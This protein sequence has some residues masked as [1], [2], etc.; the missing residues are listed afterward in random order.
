MGRG[1]HTLAVHR[2]QVSFYNYYTCELGMLKTLSTLKIKLFHRINSDNLLAL[3]TYPTYILD[4]ILN[5]EKY[6]YLLLCVIELS[7]T[8]SWNQIRNDVDLVGETL[9]RPFML[10][11]RKP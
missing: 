9:C 10:T 11:Y 2:L 4:L 8:R 6:M 1:A 3:K 5:P 7:V